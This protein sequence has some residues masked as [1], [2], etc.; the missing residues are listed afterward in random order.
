MQ[1]RILR[2]PE[3][4]VA[5]VRHEGP[6]ETVDATRRPLYQ[7]MIIHELVGGPSILRW[8]DPPV[9]NRH[10]D[11]LVT[12][13]PGFEGDAVCRMEILP[14]GE[15]AVLDYEGPMKGLADARRKLQHWIQGQGRRAAGPL[16]QV[17]H[18]DE[19]EG[20]T[21]QQLQVPLAPRPAPTHRS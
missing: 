17:H 8:I 16:L 19:M 21:E 13:H 12:T 20:V 9:G 3:R 1:P 7:H 5:V 2:L 18:M 10:V 14:A 4:H 15:Y 6:P 11:A